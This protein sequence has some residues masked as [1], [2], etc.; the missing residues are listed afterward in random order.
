MRVEELTSFGKRQIDL[1]WRERNSPGRRT[2]A[3][4]HYDLMIPFS[5][6]DSKAS[7]I[8]K[9]SIAVLSGTW[10]GVGTVEHSMGFVTTRMGSK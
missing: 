9:T 1:P 2:Y 10:T 4:R 8:T 6:F 7:M 3:S 5:S